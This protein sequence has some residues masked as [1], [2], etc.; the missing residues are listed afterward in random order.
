VVDDLAAD[1]DANAH[2]ASTAGLIER[3][4]RQRRNS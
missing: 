1:S 3:Y 4:R 2:D